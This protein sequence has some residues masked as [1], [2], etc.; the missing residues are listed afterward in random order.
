MSRG[1]K[2]KK[3][4]LLSCIF[5]YSILN[6][7][8]SLLP[9]SSL[10]LPLPSPP[11][12]LFLPR[13]IRPWCHFPY[14]STESNCELRVSICL[15]AIGALWYG[16]QLVG[17]GIRQAHVYQMPWSYTTVPYVMWLGWPDQTRPHEGVLFLPCFLV[18]GNKLSG[19]ISYSFSL[20]CLMIRNVDC[21][22]LLYFSVFLLCYLSF[23][24][25]SNPLSQISFHNTTPSLSP[26][27]YCPSSCWLFPLLSYLI[28]FVHSLSLSVSLSLSPITLS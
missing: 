2:K 17:P 14:T 28:C 12:L 5:N 4:G 24:P 11:H 10:I 20:R 6:N 16:R 8:H 26:T 22:R 9:L 19:I 25:C 21:D 27:S 7:I 13:L 3:G 1:D 18:L 23:L 15:L